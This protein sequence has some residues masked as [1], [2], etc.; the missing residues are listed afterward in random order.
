MKDEL[1]IKIMKKFVE[2]RA[3]SHSYLIDQGSEDNK[4]CLEATQ[5]DNKIEYLQKI[6]L[7]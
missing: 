2:L 6:K 1:G 5:L 7:T 3:K 4:N